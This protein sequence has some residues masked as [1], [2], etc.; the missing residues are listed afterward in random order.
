M[1]QFFYNSL[2]IVTVIAAIIGLR[3]YYITRLEKQE[4]EDRC[5]MRYVINADGPANNYDA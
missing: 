2:Y 3:T 5:A 4:K 1:K